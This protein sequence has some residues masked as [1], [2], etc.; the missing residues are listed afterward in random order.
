[1]RRSTCL[2]NG[3]SKKVAAYAKAVARHFIQYNFLKI[4]SSLRMTP[5]IA[6]GVTGAFGNHGHG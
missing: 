1:M 4:H 5:T 6:A 2:T 3:F